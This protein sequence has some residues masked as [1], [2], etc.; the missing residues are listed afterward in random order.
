MTILLP[1]GKE[2]GN[3]PKVIEKTWQ[4]DTLMRLQ[5]L[6][7][8]DYLMNAK[9]TRSLTFKKRK[10][11]LWVELGEVANEWADLFKFWSNKKLDKEKALLEYVDCIKFALSLGADLNIPPHHGH[12]IKFKDPIDQ[13]FFL[14][15]A[16]GEISGVDTFYDAFALLRGLGSHLGF[17]DSEV[18]KA[19]KDKTKINYE[20]KDHILGELL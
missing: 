15:V 3:D 13:I 19:F 7:D 11:A 1:N 16:I 4:F 18:E 17:T 10:L 8:Q 14:S 12:L 2:I 20:R 5:I 9:T 6:N